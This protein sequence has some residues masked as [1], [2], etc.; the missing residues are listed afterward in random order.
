MK[1]YK[2]GNELRYINT[3]PADNG[4]TYKKYKCDKC[5]EITVLVIDTLTDRIMHT[6]HYKDN[7]PFGYSVVK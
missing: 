3:K 5:N 6:K 4:K 2:C 7:Y 1:C